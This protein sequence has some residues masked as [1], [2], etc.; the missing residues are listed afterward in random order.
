MSYAYNVRADDSDGNSTLTLSAPVKPAWLTTFTDQGSGAGLLTGTPAEADIGSHNVSLRALDANATFA[1]QNFTIVVLPANYAPVIKV[2]GTDVNSTSVTMVE[3]NAST[4]SLTGLTAS[5]SDDSNGT[6]V[7]SVDTNASNGT[8]VVEGTGTAPSTVTFTPNPDV[9]GTDSFVLKVTDARAAVDTLTVN[10]NV[11]GVEDPP[12]ITQGAGPLSVTIL[13]DA[14]ATWTAADLNATDADVGD[15]LTW[16]VSSPSTDG[17]ATVSGSGASP[18]NFHYVPN[19]DFNGSDSFVVQVTDGASLTDTITISVTVSGVSD[20]PVITQG[21]GH[22]AVTMSEE[23][24][25]N[26]W[27]SP[28][29]NATDGDVGDTLTWS[30]QTNATGGVASVDGSG[31]S[32]SATFT[33]QPNTDFYGSDSFVVQVS[34]GNSTDVITVNVDVTNVN[35]APLIGDLNGTS[36][37]YF[38]DDGTIILDANA[39]VTDSDGSDFNGSI[40]TVAFAAGKDASE[41]FLVILDDNVTMVAMDS[42][43]AAVYDD[44]WTAGDDGGSGLAGWTTS[45]NSDG[46]TLYAGYFI[47]DSTSGSLGNVNTAGESF[48]LYANPAGAWANAERMFDASL[49]VGQTF[50]IRLAVNFRNGDKG[51][52]LFGP[53][54]NGQKLWNFNVG[55]NG[56]DDYYFEDKI[57]SPGTKVSL[58]LA[59]EADS[60]FTLLFEQKAANVARVSIVRETVARGIEIPMFERDFALGTTVNGFGLYNSGTNSGDENN[61]YANS[62]KVTA[63]PTTSALVG[64]TGSDVTFG[65]TIVGSFTGSGVGQDL[66]VTFNDKADASVV[67]AV[68]RQVGYRNEDNGNPTTSE[69]TIS[70]GLTDGDGGTSVGVQVTVSVS[71]VN[72]IPVFTSSAV[73]Q[74][75]AGVSYSY[76]VSSNDLDGNSTL[77]LINPVRPAWLEFNSTGPGAGA[78][79]GTPSESDIGSH[80]VSF[81]AL[82]TNDTYADQN[83]TIVVTPANYP[84][85]I[86]VNSTD[87]SSTLVSM[88]EDNASSFSLTGLTASDQDDSNATLVWAVDT[89]ASHGTTSVEGTGPNPSLIAYVPDGNFSGSD[90][91]V[92]KV[93]DA[94]GGIDTIDVNVTVLGVDDAPVIIQGSSLSTKTGDEDTTFTWTVGE[95][96]ATDGDVGNT[97]TW[98]VNTNAPNGVA[99][100]SGTGSNPTTFTYVPDGN[101]SGGDSFVVQVSDGTSADTVTVAVTVNPVND[102]PVLVQGAA[103]TVVMTED[104]G[105]SWVAPELNATDID[106]D[107]NT[108]TWSLETNATNGTATVIGTGPDPDPITYVPDG[109]FSGI[110]SFVVQV[111]DG[112]QN[113]T[114]TVTVTVNGVNDSPVLSVS[115]DITV[116]MDEGGYPTAW[117]SPELNATD[118]DVG[119]V[120][121]WSAYYVTPSDGNG[122]LTVSGTGSSPSV[123]SYAPNLD[124]N[125]SDVFYVRVSDGIENID[126][127]VT[128]TVIGNEEGSAAYSLTAPVTYAID[129]NAS[130]HFSGDGRSALSRLLVRVYPY[131]RTTC[132]Y[133][134]TIPLVA[135]HFTWEPPQEYLT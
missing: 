49:G 66:A 115:E 57:N 86:E 127:K 120:L 112:D 64:V 11:T 80:S 91:F 41:D 126:T 31:V 24:S 108:L 28:D 104:N 33:Y 15:I 65:G 97:L 85:V 87:V 83:F 123:F 13:E 98:S 94:K 35:D 53:G 34:D 75:F 62:I 45:D 55:Y 3:D 135:V 103:L 125:G 71:P 73:T 102:A 69:R 101:Y 131:L 134:R 78:L 110:D 68:L 32:S 109:N 63:E 6:L 114:I 42:A 59:Y 128:V 10:L 17:N 25:P 130:F 5:D 27:V 89:N 77:S 2:N 26:P 76:Q 67:T 122:T 36:L 121:T 84:P 88:Q 1:D 56:G 52:D 50:S 46:S 58:G 106:S 118:V 95:L 39:T 105:S 9:N 61:L 29:F 12:V 107:D 93:T 22:L 129:R 133:S 99:T 20:P 43:N 74:V 81:R 54:G 4:F 37:A 48:G 116:T 117:F 96:N 16:S 7:W 8:A 79:T 18:T 111:S 113:N 100:V 119:D 19:A 60:V 47:G 92:I 40:L 132:T 21:A 38:E 23:G 44:A 124:F 72:D 82:D 14:N 51:I 90:A 70:Y 30:V